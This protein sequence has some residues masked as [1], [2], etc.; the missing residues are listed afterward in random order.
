MQQNH[1]P[2]TVPLTF[3]DH[4]SIKHLLESL[5]VPHVEV[6][7][8]L[9]G[10]GT[11]PFSYLPI[12]GDKIDIFEA[13]GCPIEPR[14]LLD[15]HLGRLAASLR[16]LGFDC[17]YEN[18]YEDTQMVR[19]LEQDARILLTR[20]RQL[21]MRKA[22]QYG[23]CLRS[24]EPSEQL[25][26]VVQRFELAPLARPFTRCLRCNGPLEPV[27]KA[28]VLDQLETR[29]RLYYN[30]FARC[31]QCGRIYWQGSHWEHMNQWIRSLK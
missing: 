15:N 26:E 28:D 12:D 31:S 29:T 18:D 10:A 24:L 4:Q 8:I 11:V 1:R 6:G 14:F 3:E 25:P 13:E 7:K 5:G 22:V 21:L 19:L 9:N 27:N 20:D 23:Y 2:S 16:M 30:S 17:L